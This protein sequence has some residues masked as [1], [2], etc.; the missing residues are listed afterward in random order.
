[1]I[2]PTEVARKVVKEL[3]QYDGLKEENKS[4]LILIGNLENTV[5][6]QDSLIEE[7]NLKAE[8]LIKILEVR[9]QQVN[10]YDQELKV[11]Q[12]TINRLE[13]KKKLLTG[14]S[15][16]SVLGILGILVIL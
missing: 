3:V 4:Q 11:Q 14:F 10:Y 16:L 5:K 13:K 1:M 8:K 2:L 6:V 15:G 7:T 9:D 12:R